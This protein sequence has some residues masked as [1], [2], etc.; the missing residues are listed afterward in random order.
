LCFFELA[1]F[2][3]EKEFIDLKESFQNRKVV[4]VVF[5]ARFGFYE[6]SV[7]Y[8]Y[9]ML[10][11]LVTTARQIT[12]TTT[13]TAAKALATKRKLVPPFLAN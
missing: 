9:F 8:K 3:I 10:G 4:V 2:E 11:N 1:S 13:T 5:C 6:Q 7:C 12:T